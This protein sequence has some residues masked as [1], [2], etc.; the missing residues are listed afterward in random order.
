[1][2]F[3]AK[4]PKEERHDHDG[5]VGS[6]QTKRLT[7]DDADGYATHKVTFIDCPPLGSKRPAMPSLE[8]QIR[9]RESDRWLVFLHKVSGALLERGKPVHD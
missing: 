5:R 6:I 1:M 3:Q 8:C 4:D 9:H 7:A 2:E